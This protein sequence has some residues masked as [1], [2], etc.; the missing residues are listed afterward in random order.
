MNK[1]VVFDLD[2]T[3]IDSLPDI[4]YFVNETLE[5]FG[6]KKKSIGD[7]RAYIGNG[8]RNLIKRAFDNKLSE[9]ELDERLAYYACA[10][11]GSN[12]PLTI[13][14]DGIC[15]RLNKSILP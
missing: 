12:S 7:V 14:F 13:V 11:K 10:Y 2:G 4:A 1:L 6:A 8:A 3:L 15:Q 5:N 9:S